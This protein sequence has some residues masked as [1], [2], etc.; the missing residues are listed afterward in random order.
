MHVLL[1]PLH[2]LVLVLGLVLGVSVDLPLLEASGAASGVL[3]VAGAF[4]NSSYGALL[5]DRGPLPPTVLLLGGPTPHVTATHH[6]AVSVPGRPIAGVAAFGLVSSRVAPAGTPA[7]AVIQQASA[8]NILSVAAVGLPDSARS[9]DVGGA[10]SLAALAPNALVVLSNPTSAHPAEPPFKFVSADAATGE[11]SVASESTLGIAPKDGY[12]WRAAGAGFGLLAAVRSSAAGAAGVAGPGAVV[13]VF[14]FAVP[15]AAPFGPTLRKAASLPSP[16]PAA[17]II[18]VAVADVYG[19]GAPA[20]LLTWSDSTVDVLWVGD[21]A[22]DLYRAASFRLDPAANATWASVAAGAWLGPSSSAAAGSGRGGAVSNPAVLP[23][24]SQLMGLRATPPKA[25]AVAAA[26][27]AAAAAAGGGATAKPA[28]HASML[29]FARPEHWLRRRASVSGVRAMQ[30]FKSTFADNGPSVANLTAPLDA[31][32]F[33][34]V[35]ASTHTN[36]VIR[37]AL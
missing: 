5:Q 8:G 17:A 19:D 30:E 26:A 14:L 37:R 27:A 3:L 7:L 9:L 4:S 34:A 22:E 31:G 36:T 25:T 32:A 18:S 23:G 12:T 20:V 29:L 11:L 33:K 13:D 10:V 6:D 21:G 28:F 24:E 1:R 15:T 16:S 2:L 35:L